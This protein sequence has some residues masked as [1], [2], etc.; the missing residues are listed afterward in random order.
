MNINK[1]L[2]LA[3][4]KEED[5]TYRPNQAKLSLPIIIRMCKK[6]SNELKFRPI[7]VASDGLI[8]DGHHRY[9]SSVLA[10]YTLD[11]VSGYPKPSHV[12]EISWNIVD[13]ID[14]DWDTPDKIRMLNEQDARYNGMKIEDIEGIL[15]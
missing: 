15:D 9:I 11:V 6:M 3:K 13:F 14:A 8:V 2:I 10:N 12:N 4:L 5:S 7:C 1:K